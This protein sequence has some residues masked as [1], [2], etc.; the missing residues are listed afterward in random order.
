MSAAA[1]Y[2]LNSS[3]ETHPVMD[4]CSSD[5]SSCRNFKSSCS[6]SMLLSCPTKISF[7]F[8]FLASADLFHA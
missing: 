6:Y 2:R 4:I 7:V 5:E 3:S 1:R 8:C